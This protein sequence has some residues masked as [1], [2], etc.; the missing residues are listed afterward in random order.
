MISDVNPFIDFATRGGMSLVL[1]SIFRN[2]ELPK[3]RWGQPTLLDSVV[4]SS[5]TVN[6]FGK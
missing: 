5:L 4:E 2:K 3:A 1:R 6:A